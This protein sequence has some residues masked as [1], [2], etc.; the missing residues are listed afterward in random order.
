MPPVRGG[1]T[2]VGDIRLLAVPV[3]ASITP[4]AIDSFRPPTT[5]HVTGVNLTGATFAFVSRRRS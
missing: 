2:Q 3:I 5:L 4:K 1:M